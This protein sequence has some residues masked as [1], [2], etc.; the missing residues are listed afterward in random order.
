MQKNCF[1]QALSDGYK[2]MA[3]DLPRELE[4]RLWTNSYLLND[5]FLAKDKRATM[6]NPDLPEKFV[7]ELLIALAEAKN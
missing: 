4:A 3:R 2:E 6:E 1:E 5:A 7:C